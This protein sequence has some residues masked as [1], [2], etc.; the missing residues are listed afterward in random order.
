MYICIHTFILHITH[1]YIYILSHTPLFYI[2]IIFIYR[3]IH[4]DMGG[5]MCVCIYIVHNVYIMLTFIY[6]YVYLSHCVYIHE[7]CIYR[8][9]YEKYIIPICEHT[10]IHKM[11]CI[12]R[13][14][15]T[16]T[17]P[18]FSLIFLNIHT[19]K[20]RFIHLYV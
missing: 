12:Y 9:I 13:D 15:V 3:F 5:Y 10:H 2:H 17:S 7:Q 19:P 8:D 16:H 1:R 11:I 6:T 20:Y 4:T 18:S 14:S